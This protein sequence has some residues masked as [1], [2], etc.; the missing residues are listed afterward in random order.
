MK[1]VAGEPLFYF[2]YAVLDPDF[3]NWNVTL[4]N[5]AV[6]PRVVR[7][8]DTEQSAF[9]NDAMNSSRPSTDPCGTQYST[10]AADVVSPPYSTDS[11]LPV[12]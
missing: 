5:L 1:W 12:R 6:D 7:I 3:S 8:D 10:S 11:C 2:C 4:F 9:I